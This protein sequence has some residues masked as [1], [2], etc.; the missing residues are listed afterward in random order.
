MERPRGPLPD[1][2]PDLFVGFSLGSDDTD[3]GQV[4]LSL[5]L[6]LVLSEDIVDRTSLVLRR[7]RS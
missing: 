4:A 1:V 5:W 3:M 7:H 6:R 2:D